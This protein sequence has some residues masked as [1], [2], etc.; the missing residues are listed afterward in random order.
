MDSLRARLYRVRLYPAHLYRAD[1]HRARLIGLT[2]REGANELEQMDSADPPLAVHGVY[3]GRH[4][5]HHCHSTEEVHHLPGPLG[6]VAARLA[7]AH[8]SV[9]IR[10]AI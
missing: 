10:A 3:G 7:P 9:F 8:C 4:R 1:L 5:Q 2:S 6:G